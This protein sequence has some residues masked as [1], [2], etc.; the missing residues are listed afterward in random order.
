MNLSAGENVDG[1]SVSQYVEAENEVED[2][3]FEA[4]VNGDRNWKTLRKLSVMMLFRVLNWVSCFPSNQLSSV[5]LLLTRCATCVLKLKTSGIVT[6][7]CSIHM[8]TQLMQLSTPQ[9]QVWITKVS[10]VV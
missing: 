8:K 3:F 1:E 10:K 4:E 2:I 7:F 5:D 9:V 6:M